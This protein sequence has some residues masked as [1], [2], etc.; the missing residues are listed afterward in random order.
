MT[1]DEATVDAILAPGGML[2]QMEALKAE[3]VGVG[4]DEDE[5]GS[6]RGIKGKYVKSEEYGERSSSSEEEEDSK[7]RISAFVAS[8]I[9]VSTLLFNASLFAPASSRTFVHSQ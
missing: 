8:D 5:E 3:G 2:E 9:A 6:P 7:A 1:Y 4:D